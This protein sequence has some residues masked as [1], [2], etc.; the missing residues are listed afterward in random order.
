MTWLAR[1]EAEGSE[2]RPSGEICTPSVRVMLRQLR[3]KDG[4]VCSLLATCLGSVWA[5]QAEMHAPQG[6]RLVLLLL[7]IVF[8]I[9]AGLA[10]IRCS[11]TVHLLDRWVNEWKYTFHLRGSIFTHCVLKEP[12]V[13]APG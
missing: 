8:L 11:R 12:F 5:D 7:A 13:S 2:G 4:F 3:E 6:R 1:K 9:P 10:D